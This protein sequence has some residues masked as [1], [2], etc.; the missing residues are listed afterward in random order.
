MKSLAKQV[1]A[2]MDW[3]S[4]ESEGTFGPAD[5]AAQVARLQPTLPAKN[6]CKRQNIEQLIGDGLMTPRYIVEL[7][8]AMGTTAEELKH[9]GYRPPNKAKPPGE[10]ET[11]DAKLEPDKP[12]IGYS[13][14]SVRGLLDLAARGQALPD[15]RQS[16]LIS[17]LGH[18]ISK[19]DEAPQI[20]EEIAGLLG[21]EQA[22]KTR[23]PSSTRSPKR[24]SG[25]SS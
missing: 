5:M 23:L 10:H 2:Y 25:G 15:W 18:L 7:A 13:P 1:Q 14:W 24:R 9:G 21:V 17:M 4:S 19:P 3:R 6:R 22:K 20:A 16:N 8:Q 12:D 11:G